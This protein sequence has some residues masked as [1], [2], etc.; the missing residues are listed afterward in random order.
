MQKYKI[1][2]NELKIGERLAWH[3]F[4]EDE[5][6][7]LKRG[8]LIAAQAQI[9]A[10]LSRG[11]WYSP[12]AEINV[13]DRDGANG[14]AHAISPF[15][16]IHD[17]ITSLERSMQNT[18]PESGHLERRIT[19]LATEIVALFD[20]ESDPL[21]G[22]V[23]LMHEYD[24]AYCH[25]VH[26]SILTNLLMQGLEYDQERRILATCAT[27][28]A[29]ISMNSLQAILQ[30]QERPLSQAQ[31]VAIQQHPLASI[32]LLKKHGINNE[33]WLEIV[34][35]HH[36]KLDGSG[37]PR[38]LGGDVLL[39]EARIIG[40]V[41]RYAAMVSKR[42]YR[43][44]MNPTDC[45]RAFFVDKGKQYDEKLSLILIR[46]LGI[47]PPGICVKLANGETAVV[48]KRRDDKRCPLVRAFIGAN[49]KPYVD[50][51]PRDTLREE[52]AIRQACPMRTDYP[53]SLR[54]VWGYKRV[55]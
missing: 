35:Q 49:G 54:N 29:N 18:A 38:G 37:Y 52:Y 3:V 50:S 10:I 32:Q 44:P 17:V 30:E 7:L 40:M 2:P 48:V 4:S 13:Q 55:Q 51:L 5:L 26:V 9:D 20:Q 15:D 43:E 27:L 19:H 39:E 45:L 16:R 36:E 12:N 47:F 41:D 21:I 33:R 25:A 46:D 8:T 34:H 11:G 24:Y 23:H 53:V 1:M 28:T 6:L 14:G 22:A 42:A 31:K